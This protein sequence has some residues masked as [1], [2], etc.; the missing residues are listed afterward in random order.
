MALGS[1]PES[2]ILK[3]EKIELNDYE[4]IKIDK[5][6]MTSKDKVFASGDIAGTKSTVAWAARSGRDAAEIIEKFLKT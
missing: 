4:Y 2:N 6:N 1:K 3:R 5:N